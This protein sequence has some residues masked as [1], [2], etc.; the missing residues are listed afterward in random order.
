MWYL[1]CS[2]VMAG[3]FTVAA[4]AEADDKKAPPGDKPTAPKLEGTYTIETGE[5][6][7]K[8]IP[9][10][11]IKGAIVLFTAEM[12]V[13]TDKDKKELFSASYTLDTSKKPYRLTMKSKPIGDPKK[14]LTTMPDTPGLVEIDGDKIRLIYALPG[15]KAPTEFATKEL[16][17][18]FVLKKQMTDK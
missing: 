5:R 2:L 9:A 1:T 13:G 14:D 7:G 8:E 10:E 12:V 3:I 18:L 4:V 6:D 17:H 15:G 16:Q 11:R